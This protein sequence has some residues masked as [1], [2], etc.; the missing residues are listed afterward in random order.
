LTDDNKKEFALM[1]R[2]LWQNYG[3]RECET[4]TM[5]YWFETLHNYDLQT[6][7]NAVH[8]WMQEN[9]SNLP[10]IKNI[11]DICKPREPEYKAL[12]R[13]NSKEKNKEYANNVIDFVNKELNKPSR[14]WIK[15]WK[16]ILNTKGLPMITY[17][18]ARTALINLGV[19]Q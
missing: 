12:P 11:I 2:V 4:S 7:G 17:T 1:M 16:D 6:V 9:D 8:K 13:P 5:K 3:K 18:S 19:K 10:S 14:D 15:Y